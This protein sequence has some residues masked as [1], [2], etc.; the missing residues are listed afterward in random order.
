MS[1][2]ELTDEQK[3]TFQAIL[4]SREGD[5]EE[6]FLHS[7]LMKT[8]KDAEAFMNYLWPKQ[9]SYPLMFRLLEDILIKLN[10]K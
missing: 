10:T 6:T 1:Y 2:A 3:K 4:D 9:N 8:R 7:R 5:P